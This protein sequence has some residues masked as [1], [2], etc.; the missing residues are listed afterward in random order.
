MNKSENF[1]PKCGNEVGKSATGT[2]GEINCMTGAPLM[3]I[4]SR[5][6]RCLGGSRAP[7]ESRRSIVVRRAKR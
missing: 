3:Q 5:V 7:L 1:A 4:N 6:H 2:V